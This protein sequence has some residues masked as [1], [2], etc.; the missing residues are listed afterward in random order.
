MK[1][2]VRTIFLFCLMFCLLSCKAP[3]DKELNNDIEQGKRIA[4]LYACYAENQSE[5]TFK[6]YYENK[7]EHELKEGVFFAVTDEE[8][9]IT[10]FKY[11]GNTYIVT[12]DAKNP[13]DPLNKL[14]TS[15]KLNDDT[16]GNIKTKYRD[17]A[18]KE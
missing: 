7:M 15:E 1:Y 10:S 4:L 12:Y 3:K 16:I 6:E 8:N 18:S 2:T 17:L 5:T 11:I 9:N 14:T 13:T